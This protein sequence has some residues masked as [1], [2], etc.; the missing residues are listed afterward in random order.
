MNEL[1]WCSTDCVTVKIRSFVS[2]SETVIDDDADCIFV[3][4]VEFVYS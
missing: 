1:W 2:L 4:A 3:V